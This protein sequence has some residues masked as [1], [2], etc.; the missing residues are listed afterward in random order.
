MENS[1]KHVSGWL[2]VR[3]ICFIALLTAAC[4]VGRTAFQFI[5]N[6]QPITTMFI[7]ISLYKGFTRGFLVMLL[8]ILTTNI[9]MGMG[10]WTLTQLFS[11]S[12]IILVSFGL[13]KIPGFSQRKIPQ[14]VFVLLAGYLFGF[15][16]A[17]GDYVI[18]GI[19]AFW[20]YYLQGIYFDTMHGAGNFLFYLLL[21]P[22]VPRLFMRY[23]PD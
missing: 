10:P 19:R 8:T 22:I 16:T 15:L 6:V 9:Y 14:L 2:T 12:V 1:N 13:S 21:S 4:V 20:P 11:Y 3:D 23:W 17:C 5:P 18:Y 7:L